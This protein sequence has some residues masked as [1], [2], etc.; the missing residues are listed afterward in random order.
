[1][2]EW[3]DNLI[4]KCNRSARWMPNNFEVHHPKIAFGISMIVVCGIILPYMLV[5][6]PI[7]KLFFGDSGDGLDIK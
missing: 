7:L 6:R 4:E 5:L 1:M 3:F 2:V